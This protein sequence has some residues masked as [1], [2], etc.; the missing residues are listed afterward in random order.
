VADGVARAGFDVDLRHG[1]AREAAFVSAIS[2]AFVECKSDAKARSTG[3]VFVEIRQGASDKGRGRP[4]GLSISEA[5]W[6]AIEYEDDCWL[7]VRTSLLKSLTRRAKAE[8]G[9]VMGGDFNRFEGVLVPVEW[10]VRPFK[11][12]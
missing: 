11:A 8:R 4:S 7:V 10:F 6:Y 9:T 2:R 1:E 12:A 3:N 5:S